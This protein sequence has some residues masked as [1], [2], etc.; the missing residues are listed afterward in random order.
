MAKFKPGESGNPAGKVPGTLN[1][2]TQVV[3][4]KIDTVIND[5]FGSEQLKADLKQLKP[6]E[7]WKVLLRLFE[8]RAPKMRATE[9]KLDIFEHLSD[10]DLDRIID[11]LV[12]RANNET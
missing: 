8:F 12:N 4:E 1:R 7:R 9:M 6:Y 10:N 11:E 2:S 5:C 3:L